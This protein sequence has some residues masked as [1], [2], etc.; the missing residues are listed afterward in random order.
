MTGTG[1]TTLLEQ[2]AA[3]IE[4]KKQLLEQVQ[5]LKAELSELKRLIYGSKRERFIPSD[6][7]SK[8]LTLPLDE[9]VPAETP[10]K[11]KQTISYQRVAAGEKQPQGSSR[12]PLPAHL[13]RKEVVLEPEVDTTHMR[14]IGEEIT[15]ELDMTPAKVFVR[16]YIRPRYVSKEEEFYIANLPARPIG[17]GI[18][19]PGLLAHIL[20]DKFCH[21]LPFY[22]QQK[23]FNQ[24]GIKIAPSTLGNW[25]KPACQLLAPLYQALKF[26]VLHNNYLQVD[27]SPIKVLDDTKK[28]KTHRGY[29]WTYYSPEQQV[30]LFDYQKG[31][32]REGPVNMLQ[33]YEGYIQTDG[34]KVYDQLLE[35]EGMNIILVGCMAH[36]RRYFEKALD[37]DES[38][39]KHALLLF[40]QLYAIEREA[41]DNELDALQRYELRQEKSRPI[42]DLLGQWIVAEYPKVLPKSSI[43][44]AMHYLAERY[45]KLYVYLNDGR[46]EIDCAATVT[47]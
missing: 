31:R 9:N 44:K 7:N 17:K 46:L 32:S 2:N 45:N 28:G 37:N 27:E 23:R 43:G 29:Y 39:A 42:M 13:P 35:E 20:V 14:K 36:V 18:P 11:V 26:E 6:T 8:Q 40:Q 47:T 41:R 1:D 4:E 10:A 21:H 3:L 5:L 25:L 15:E 33:G 34:Y 22:R 38:R 24:L 16:R 30:V 12:Q 19:G